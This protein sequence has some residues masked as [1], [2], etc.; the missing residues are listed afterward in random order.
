[1]IFHHIVRGAGMKPGNQSF[2]HHAC[3]VLA[4]RLDEISLRQAHALFGA[5]V[6]LPLCRHCST[7]ISSQKSQISNNA[8]QSAFHPWQS[9]ARN[10]CP[11]EVNAPCPRLTLMHP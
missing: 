2:D 3:P 11:S 4:L 1:M 10:P 8:S 6:E 7:S 5:R 9:L